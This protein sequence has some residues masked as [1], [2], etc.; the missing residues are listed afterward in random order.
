MPQTGTRLAYAGDLSHYTG[1][2]HPAHSQLKDPANYAQIESDLT[3][4]GFAGLM[5]PPRPEVRNAVQDC[6]KAGIR[7]QLIYHCSLQSSPQRLSITSYEVRR[8]CENS[9]AGVDVVTYHFF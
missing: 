5:D 8:F 4:L 6:Q 2:Q 9:R 7:V 1:P 3:L